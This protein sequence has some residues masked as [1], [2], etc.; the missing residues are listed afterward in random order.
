MSRDTQ[1]KS[2]GVGFIG[3][4]QIVLITLKLLD[5]IDWSWWFVLSPIWGSVALFILIV[6][7]VFL[8][9]CLKE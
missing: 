4:L 7:G 5:K 2:G 3:L 1:A 9:C 6:S 8:Y